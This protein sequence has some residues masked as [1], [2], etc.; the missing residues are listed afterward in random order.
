MPNTQRSTINLGLSSTPEVQDPKLF[1]EFV[2]LYNAINLLAQYIDQYSLDG[3]VAAKVA[4]LMT[5]VAAINESITNLET[6]IEGLTNTI[7]D[8]KANGVFG[9]LV[10]TGGFGANG[11]TAQL[12]KPTTANATDLATAI[13]LV[14][15]LKATL[16]A[17]GISS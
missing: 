4:T 3:T 16:V 14:N 11:T 12:A 6:E 7:T 17:N 9:T 5:D 1:P 10:V 13:A 15:N 2:R 8:L